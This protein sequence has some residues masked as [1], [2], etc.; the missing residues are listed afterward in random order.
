MEATLLQVRDG[1]LGEDRSAMLSSCRQADRHPVVLLGGKEVVEMWSL[2]PVYRTTTLRGPAACQPTTTPPTNISR[3]G[4]SCQA[5]SFV[6][7]YVHLQSVRRKI[8]LLDHQVQ[9]APACLRCSI[10]Q[11]VVAPVI[12]HEN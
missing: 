8:R 2:I 4:P 12:L 3:I 5:G 11:T 6:G 10:R 1:I 7:Q 9:P